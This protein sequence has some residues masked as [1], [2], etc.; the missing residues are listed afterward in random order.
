MLCCWY[1]R[2]AVDYAD[3]LFLASAKRFAVV[4]APQLNGSVNYVHSL[5]PATAR[6]LRYSYLKIKYFTNFSF[7]AVAGGVEY[8]AVARNLAG[9]APIWIACPCAPFSRPVSA[10]IKIRP[11]ADCYSYLGGENLDNSEWKVPNA[12]RVCFSRG[13]G[14]VPRTARL[15]HAATGPRRAVTLRERSA[16]GG[17]AG[18][19]CRQCVQAG[20]TVFAVTMR[21][22]R[23]A[24][25]QITACGRDCCPPPRP[26]MP[27]NI[28][29]RRA[30][31][32]AHRRRADVPRL[33]G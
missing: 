7:I 12:V 25:A 16:K 3:C 20:A 5:D 26:A 13:P 4:F 22:S 2:A 24:R 29:E 21:S 10:R 19:C 9:W 33:A 23:S 32:S 18:S 17:K 11:P 14:V 31:H 8:S 30:A 1:V 6:L 28:A 15:S 27:P